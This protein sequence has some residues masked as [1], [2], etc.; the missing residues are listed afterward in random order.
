MPANPSPSDRRRRLR[1]MAFAIYCVLLFLFLAIG[2]ELAVRVAG[3]RPY[4]LADLPVK[5]EPGG[6]FFRRHPRLGYTQIPGEYKITLPDGYAFRVT[7]GAN[8]L[9]I[10]HPPLLPTG[11]AP[12]PAVWIMG[13]SFVHGW[14]LNDEDTLPWQLQQAL[15]EFEISNFGVNG[16]GN[17]H[18]LLQYREFQTT[19]PK[20]V[21]VV[22]TYAYFHDERNTL[23][24]AR[25][26]A[27]APY[28]HLGPVAL[29]YARL[30]ADGT[31]DL[32]R[33]AVEYREWPLQRHSALVHF[34]EQK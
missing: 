2:A 20:P 33:E 1:R 25:R 21:C 27:V 26:K 3:G 14:S 13:C 34:L 29:P 5:V 18:G 12:R 6:R 23:T 10:T 16:Y 4:R 11:A 17:L 8:T 22:A 28:N 15:P 31:L 32:R 30:A 19:Q 24:R 7:H 9:R